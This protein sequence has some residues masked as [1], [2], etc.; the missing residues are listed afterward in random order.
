[1]PQSQTTEDLLET[2]TEDHVDSRELEF[3]KVMSVTL[4][5]NE[6]VSEMYVETANVPKSIVVEFGIS[7]CYCG[8]VSSK[9][10]SSTPFNSRPFKIYVTFFREYST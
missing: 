5:L 8:I 10:A 2:V 4:F 3:T 6:L 9:T 1:M 7:N